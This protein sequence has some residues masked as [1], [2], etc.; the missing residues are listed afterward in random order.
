MNWDILKYEIK[1]LFRFEIIA[2]IRGKVKH[3]LSFFFRF[4]ENSCKA[5]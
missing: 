3:P 2:F 4:A 1:D 5:L